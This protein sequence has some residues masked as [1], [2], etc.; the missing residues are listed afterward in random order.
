VYNFICRTYPSYQNNKAMVLTE[1]LSE[2][3]AV[4]RQAYQKFIKLNDEFT[5]GKKNKE[6]VIKLT[7]YILKTDFSLK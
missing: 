1:K 6:D 4:L 5:S 3:S 7:K 2:D